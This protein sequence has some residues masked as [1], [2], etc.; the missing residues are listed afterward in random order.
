MIVG[1]IL[2]AALKI[3]EISSKQDQPSVKVIGI[4]SPENL[5]TYTNEKRKAILHSVS[6]RIVKRFIQF[7]FNNFPPKSRNLKNDD[8]VHNYS[9]HLLSI[10]CFYLAYKDAIKEG[11]G[12]CVLD[13]WHYL[14]PIFINSGCRNYSNEALH[15]LCQY[16]Q[17]SSPAVIV[18]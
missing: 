18:Q 16:H 7:S 17:D 15:Y 1:H 5:W 14:L 13:Y 10:G 6:G 8:Q 12:E 4:S 11:D 3:L 9:C 2:A